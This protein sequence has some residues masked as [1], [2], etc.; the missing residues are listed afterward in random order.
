MKTIPDHSP[1]ILV[2]RLD[3][4]ITIFSH[5]APAWT[6]ITSDKGYPT[7]WALKYGFT[8]LQN[9]TTSIL[10]MVLN[11][12]RSK[13][14]LVLNPNYHPVFIGMQSGLDVSLDSI[15]SSIG[16]MIKEIME[17][18]EELDEDDMNE[19]SAKL[20]LTAFV[21]Q[22]YKSRTIKDALF[23]LE[24]TINGVNELGIYIQYTQ[25]KIRGYTYYIL[26]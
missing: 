2:H 12:E 8:S 5:K 19:T 26:Y 17:S 22:I 4:P 16:Q 21:F 23:S 20:A 14:D 13:A 6:R 1:E 15:L 11:V 3:N 24:D 25:A 7:Y 10:D 18:K 9:D